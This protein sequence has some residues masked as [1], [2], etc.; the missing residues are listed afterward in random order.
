MNARYG[1]CDLTHDEVLSTADELG[2]DWLRHMNILFLPLPDDV[3]LRVGRD[4]AYWWSDAIRPDSPTKRFGANFSTATEAAAAGLKH[5]TL[6]H[7]HWLSDSE[8]RPLLRRF[9]L[10]DY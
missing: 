6:N 5:C 4:G 9:E 3:L 1:V 10:P 2:S 7:V 8:L